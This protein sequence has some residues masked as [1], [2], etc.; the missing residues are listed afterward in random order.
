MSDV[1]RHL[2][3]KIDEKCEQLKDDAA[4]GKAATFEDYKFA[5]GIYR[6]LMLAKDMIIEVHEHLEQSDD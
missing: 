1:L 5:C 4:A 3:M 2:A 6:G